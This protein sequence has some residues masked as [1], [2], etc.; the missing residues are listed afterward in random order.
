MPSFFTEILEKKIINS[1]V[2][3]KM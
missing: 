1:M 3:W 2:L